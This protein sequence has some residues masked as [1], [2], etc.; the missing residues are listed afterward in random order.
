M[1]LPEGHAWEGPECGV[2]AFT[3]LYFEK[4]VPSY[5][6]NGAKVPE[7]LHSCSQLGRGH[8]RLPALRLITFVIPDDQTPPKSW[9]L[10]QTP[11]RGEARSSIG[12]RKPKRGEHV[13]GNHGVW[14]EPRC[15]LRKWPVF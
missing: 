7:I 13:I 6:I 5:Y 9:T 11:L 3:C 8:C 12:R 10:R 15:Q 2:V 1:V 4:S 14:Y